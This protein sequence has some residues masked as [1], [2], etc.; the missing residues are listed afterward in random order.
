MAPSAD[1]TAP[2]M[3]IHRAHRGPGAFTSRRGTDQPMSAPNASIHMRSDR[4]HW[5]PLAA[6]S[7]ATRR[8]M[9][10]SVRRPKDPRDR[11]ATATSGLAPSRAGQPGATPLRVTEV[12]DRHVGRPGLGVE[13]RYDG[14]TIA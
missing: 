11:S 3:T 5:L 2:K 1:A 14:T 6:A 12:H 10:P 8:G 7:G 4:S 9:A 13:E